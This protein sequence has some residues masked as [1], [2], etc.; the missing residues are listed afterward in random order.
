VNRRAARGSRLA[1]LLVWLGFV[2]VLA[3]AFAAGVVAGRWWPGLG[4]GLGSRAEASRPTEGR[5]GGSEPASAP[6]RVP[7]LTFYHELTA[8]L[9]APA[10]PAPPAR[11]EPARA[12]MGRSEPVRAEPASRPAGP[13]ATAAPRYALQVGAFRQREGAEALRARLRAAGYEA[14]VWEAD[15]GPARYRVRLGAFATRAEAERLAG[16]LAARLGAPAFVTTR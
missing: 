9:S 5:P 13:A 12:G 10:V 2:T 3:A 15:G 11:P 7:A 16:E 4:P 14:T 8:P 1:S 6:P